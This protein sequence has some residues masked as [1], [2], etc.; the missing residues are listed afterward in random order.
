MRHVSWSRLL[1]DADNNVLGFLPQAF[2][3][4]PTE[5]ALSVNWLEY[6]SGDRKSQISACVKQFRDS[7]HVS[8][9]SAFGVGNVGKIQRTCMELGAKVR[10]VYAPSKVNPAHAE[11]RNLPRDELA[12]LE[13]LAADVFTEMIHNTDIS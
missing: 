4:R 9:K 3:L 11:L 1:K 8:P 12:L 13:A 5:P 2:D 7:R 10:I 6:F